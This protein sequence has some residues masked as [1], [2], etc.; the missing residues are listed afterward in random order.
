MLGKATNYLVSADVCERVRVVQ[1]R[2]DLRRRRTF[3]EESGEGPD[4]LLSMGRR[5]KGTVVDAF[6]RARAGDQSR[7]TK[8]LE[9]LA[10]GRDAK[11]CGLPFGRER[12]MPKFVGDL[13]DAGM[14]LRLQEEAEKRESAGVGQRG[15]DFP[16]S[17]FVALLQ[18]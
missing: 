15:A 1:Q 18:S 9:V 13:V 2:V 14:P 6:V 10:D 4:D 16:E 11:V 17:I 7:L 8:L 5:G 3:A 12:G